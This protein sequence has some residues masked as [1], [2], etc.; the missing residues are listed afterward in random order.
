M[1]LI[2]GIPNAG[3]TTY[4]NQYKD[5]THYDDI[6]KFKRKDRISFY[7]TANIIEGIYNSVRSRKCI[8]DVWSIRKGQKICIWLNTPKE[9]CIRREHNYRQ[10]PDGLVLA[11]AQAFEPPTYAEGWDLIIIVNESNS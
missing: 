5:V 4:A 8:L 10:R 3:K 6:S 7:K 9:E 2:C 11:H 1:I